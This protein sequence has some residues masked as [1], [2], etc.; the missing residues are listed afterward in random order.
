M[1]T[2]KIIADLNKGEKLTGTNYDIWHKKMT[3]L[4][5]EQ[6]LFEHLT[7]I[8]TRPPEGNTAQSRR[9]LEAFETWSK[10]DR[11]A[12]FTLLSCMHDDLIGAYEHCATAKEMRDQL[13]FDF[14]GTSVTRL[15][16]LVLKFEMYKKDP[17]NSMT[18]HQRIISAM[19]RDLKNAEVALSDEQ[20]VQAVIRSLPD[21]WVSMRQ[22]L[23]HNGNI[24]NFAD[25]S[26]HVELEAEREEAIRATALFA[27]GG[28][29][30]G[31]WSK[32]KNKGKSSTK[33]GSS[34]QGPRV[35]R[36]SKRH[37]GKRG[38]IF[39]MI[40]LVPLLTRNYV[41]KRKLNVATLVC[42]L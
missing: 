39:H 4:L 30:H 40:L 14:G 27:Q 36:V 29:R 9:D 25:V 11:C 33:E 35:G 34:S 15:R 1:A 21:S 28:K 18:E 24:K 42:T 5:N 37:R 6:E 41:K 3:F 22:I 26:R 7:T 16:S 32:R 31:H 19:I 17:K 23:T 10:K 2:K 12:R 8:M 13:R 20:Q 38:G